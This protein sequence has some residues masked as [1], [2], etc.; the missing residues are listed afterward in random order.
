MKFDDLLER[1]N[2]EACFDFASVALLFPE[3][4]ESVR[5]ALYR[6][7]KSGKLLEL[8][9][10]LYA[11]ADRYR[12]APLP[13]PAVAGL[14]YSPSYLSERWALSW[15]GMIPEKTVVFTSVT[16]RPTKRFE[17][18]WGSF[19]YRS[20]KPALFSGFLTETILGAPVRLAR[21]E[22]ALL[23]LWHLE[24]GE[25]TEARL[26]S[27]RLEPGL[28]EPGLVLAEAAKSGSPRLARAAAAW[29]RYAGE[30]RDGRI[31]L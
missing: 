9:R 24:G 8:R 11:F 6:F 2:R 17:N 22:K 10:G 14:L 15:Y 29:L 3:G 18:A 7:R 13:G 26:E 4:D 1:F 16:P 31:E 27:M 19:A 20:L 28:V 25:W 12:K 23:D 21:P 5:T 30:A